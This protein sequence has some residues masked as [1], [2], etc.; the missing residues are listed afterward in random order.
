MGTANS[1]AAHRGRLAH[2]NQN[3]GAAREVGRTRARSFRLNDWIGA[4][5]KLKC[6][7]PSFPNGM[8]GIQALDAAMACLGSSADLCKNST[9]CCAPG[10]QPPRYSSFETRKK[11]SRKIQVTV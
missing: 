7:K 3:N 8:R 4:A 5:K 1:R 10:A 11:F 9:I 2:R 6:R